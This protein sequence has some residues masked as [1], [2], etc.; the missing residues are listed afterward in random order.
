MYLLEI[1]RIL[2]LTR[3]EGAGPKQT[4]AREIEARR[5]STIA[6]LK[7]RGR[8]IKAE[9]SKANAAGMETPT[10]DAGEVED[11]GLGGCKLEIAAWSGALLTLY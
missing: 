9:T 2:K 11:D 6:R 8:I 1:R 7:S 5:P 10:T 4:R 3:K